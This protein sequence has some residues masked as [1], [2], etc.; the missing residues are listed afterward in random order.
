MKKYILTFCMI[1]ISVCG[2]MLSA[3]GENYNSFSLHFSSPSI[4]IEQNT[5]QDYEIV[6]ENYFKSNLDFEFS[7][8]SQIVE[9]SEPIDLGNGHYRVTILGHTPGSATLKITLL[10]GKK[11]IIIPVVVYEPISSISLKEDKDLYVLRGESLQ[12][13]S[14]MFEFYPPSTLE[15]DIRFQIGTQEIANGLIT[16][17]SETESELVVTAVSLYDENITCSFVVRVLDEIETQNITLSLDNTVIPTV[18]DEKSGYIE[19]IENDSVNYQKTLTFAYDEA[20]VYEIFTKSTKNPVDIVKNPNMENFEQIIIQATDFALREDALVIR[21][22]YADYDAYYVDLEYSVHVVSKPESILFNG[23]A[24]LGLINLFDNNNEDSA[25]QFLLSI[26]PQSADYTY[27]TLEFYTS[28]DGAIEGASYA[29]LSRYIC[30]KYGVSETYDNIQIDDLTIPIEVYGREVLP[31]DIGDEIVIRFVVQDNITS[32]IVYGNLRFTIQK[33]ATS[34]V[35]NNIYPNSTIYVKNGQTVTF[36]D[37]I[38]EETDAYVGKITAKPYDLLSSNYCTVVQTQEGLASIDITA[39]SVGEAH[40]TLVLESGLSTRITIVVKEELDVDNLWFYVSSQDDVVA[41]VEYRQFGENETLDFV[42]VR[43]LGSIRISANIPH[44]DKIDTSMYSITYE[45]NSANIVVDGNTLTFTSVDNVRNTVHIKISKLKVE[46]FALVVDEDI[47]NATT[48]DFEVICFK[49]ITSFNFDAQNVGDLEDSYSSTVNVYDLNT[50]LGYVDTSLALLQFRLLLDGVEIKANDIL[51]E[52]LGLTF[53][54]SVSSTD[55]GAGRYELTDAGSIVYGYFDKNQLTFEC[56]AV[57]SPIATFTIT[58]TIYEYGNAITSSVQV[59]IIEYVQV[60]ELWL[61]NRVDDIYLDSTDRPIV[62][63]PY[64]LP[65]NATNKNFTAWFEPD[66]GTSSTILQLQYDSNSITISYSGSGGGNGVINIVPNSLFEGADRNQYSWGLSIPISVGDGSITSPLHIGTWEQFKNIDLSK[67]YIIDGTIDANGEEISP[68]GELTGGIRGVIDSKNGTSSSITNFVVKSP[69]TILQ[70]QLAGEY[71]GLFSS[72]SSGAYV[73]NLSISGKIDVTDIQRNAYIGLIAGVNNGVIKNVSVTLN[74]ST[75]NSQSTSALY[76]GGGVGQ[77]NSVYVVDI[78]E[79]KANEQIFDKQNELSQNGLTFD[80][81]QESSTSGNI[82]T[83]YETVLPQSTMF[84]Y[85][86][87]GQTLNVSVGNGNSFIG[88]VVG[89]NT[90]L[91]KFRKQAD[92]TTFNNFGVSAQ[93]NIKVQT[94]SVNHANAGIGGFVGQNNGGNIVNILI[95][96]DVSAQ[97]S[98]NVGGLVGRMQDGKVLNNTSRVFVRGNTYVAGLIGYVLSGSIENITGNTVQAT[99]DRQRVGLFATL[100]VS[101]NESSTHQILNSA[102]IDADT[103]ITDQTNNKAL[104]YITRTKVAYT[105]QNEAEGDINTYYG[106][107]VVG[108]NIAVGNDKQFEK[109]QDVL[110]LT[111]NSIV[112]NYFGAKDTENQVYLTERNTQFLPSDIFVGNDEVS[113]TS[114]T[115]SIISIT[116]DGRIKVHGTGTAILTLTSPLNA[117]IKKQLKCV[118]TNYATTLSLYTTADYSS[119]LS[120]NSVINVSNRDSVTLYPKL[121]AYV[122]EGNM[123]IALVDNISAQLEIVSNEN[124]KAMQSANTIILQGIGTENSTTAEEISFYVYLNVDGNKRYLTEVDGEYKFVEVAGGTELNTPNAKIYTSYTQGIYNIESDKTNITLVPSDVFSIKVSY[125]TDD[126]LDEINLSVTYQQ[127]GEVFALGDDVFEKYFFVTYTQP[128]LENGRYF[129]DYTFEMNTDEVVR[130][131]DYTFTFSGANG[132]VTKNVYVTYE[133]QP[134]NNVIVKNYS[135]TD[136]ED[137]ILIDTGDGYYVYNTSYTMTETNIVTA[138]EPN[139]LKVVINPSFADYSYVEITNSTENI[140]KGNVVLFGLLQQKD[141]TIGQAVISSN[142]FFTSTGIRV[143]KQYILGG[144]LNVLYRMATNVVEGDYIT[145]NINFYNDKGEIVYTQQQKV[146]TIALNKSVSV[147]IANKDIEDH[148]Y[149]ARGYNYLLNVQTVGY[150]ITDVVIQ[151]SSPYGEIVKDN[152]AYYLRIADKVNYTRGQE[153]YDFTVTYYGTTT[154]DGVTTSGIRQSFTCTIVEY[155]LADLKNLDEVFTNSDIV[156]NRGSSVDVRDVIVD[157]IEVEYSGSAST[158]VNELKQSLRQNGVYFYKFDEQNGYIQIIPQD[159]ETLSKTQVSNQIFD[160][161]GYDLTVKYVGEDLFSL[162]VFARLQYVEGFVQVLELSDE[163]KDDISDVDIREFNVTVNQSTSLESPLP[164]YTEEDLLNMSAGNYYILM[165]NITIS[166]NYTPIDVAIAQLDGNN[167]NIIF[168]GIY[169]TYNNVENFGLFSVVDKSTV[170]RNLT[171]VVGRN[172]TFNFRNESN[173]NPFNFGLICAQNNGTITN[174]QVICQDD[175]SSLIVTNSALVA[176]TSTSNIASFVAVNNGY[177]TN[178]RVSLRIES[179]GANLSGFVAENN[180]HIASSYVKRSLIR[181]SSTNVNN[182][183]AGFVVRNSGTI[184][185]SYIEGEYTSGLSYLYASDTTFIIR[186]TSIAGAFAYINDGKISNCYANIPL[187]S[188]SVNSGFV[189]T[190][191]GEIISSYTT[192]KLGDRDTGNYPFYISSSGKIEDSYY[193]SDENF[194]VGINS[195]NSAYGEGL[196]QTLI[197]E[198]ATGYAVSLTGSTYTLQEKLF[199][200]FA[201]NSNQDITS[202][203]WFY[204]LDN[205]S[206]QNTH[207]LNT[208]ST[209]SVSDYRNYLQYSREVTTTLTNN[210]QNLKFR[211]NRPQLVSANII[212]S[213]SKYIASMQYVEET[214]ETLYTYAETA[215]SNTEGSLYNPHIIT[216]AVMFEQNFISN[217]IRYTNTQYYRLVKD[218]DYTSENLVVSSLYNYVLAGYFEGNGLTISN[219][220][221][222]TNA[223]MTSGGYFSQ[224]G[225]G[226]DYAT[227]QNVTFVPRYINLPNVISAGTVAGTVNRVYAYNITVDGYNSDSTS[228]V[229]LGKNIVG[230]VFGRTVSSFDIQNIYSSISTNAYQTNSS[231]NWSSDEVQSEILYEEGSSNYNTVSYS[232]GIIGYLGG[233]G[234]LKNAYITDGIASIGMV[235]GFMFGGVGLNAKV[236]DV[237]YQFEND[238]NNFI[239]ASAYAGVIV[240]DL[241][242]TLENVHVLAPK[243][244]DGNLLN[245]S[246]YIFV[247]T[248]KVP[249]A[250]GGICG[251]VRGSENADANLVDCSS[252]VNIEFKESIIVASVGGLVG[253][254][255]ENITIY[256]CGYYGEIVTGKN[257]VGGIIGEIKFD[258]TFG[259]VNLTNVYVGLKDGDTQNAVKTQVKA[260]KPAQDESISTYVGGLIGC[261]TSEYN[262]SNT[263]NPQPERLVVTGAKIYADITSDISIYGTS[264][265]GVDSTGEVA[266]IFNLYASK[267]IGGYNGTGTFLGSLIKVSQDTDYSGIQLNL[268]LKNLRN[269]VTGNQGVPVEYTLYISTIMK[270]VTSLVGVDSLYINNVSVQGYSDKSYLVIKYSGVT[271][272][273]DI[274]A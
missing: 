168:S 104:S 126:E 68:L 251:I 135:F 79:K 88:G 103:I 200:G 136:N 29:E 243:D 160:L 8:D 174:C 101:N 102:N 78:V 240:G 151:S 2:V 85:M 265:I 32:D 27:I 221:I 232:G 254:V 270:D 57:G 219:F 94:T 233:L 147:S 86:P 100:I 180:G 111:T 144:E 132:M 131:G 80:N 43:G 139:I 108:A 97:S 209:I 223:G 206:Y 262:F 53:S 17:D 91:L 259:I 119:L 3:C 207:D 169:S 6:V 231:G 153:G 36:N 56:D 125:L 20:Y 191:N 65:Q 228:K 66:D 241:K 64:I 261:L 120:P 167:F 87:N 213:S 205:N 109:V 154:V 203:V 122:I 229:V 227:I 269:N 199:N 176:L 166:S 236:Q 133:L 198:F 177:I 162:G 35:V 214:G 107:I 272:S 45:S 158:A 188:S 116:A 194:N 123:K 54:F 142:A 271:E 268:K 212:A 13:D 14:S 93:V 264:G 24:D 106:E 11:Q 50:P 37:F 274:I 137:V 22:K 222:N 124:V 63:Y 89:E 23:Q 156:L 163:E 69:Y 211:S 74:E 273:G 95:T 9:I 246:Y 82:N 130:V 216:S 171:I 247:L 38:V 112:L 59:S 84:V 179:Y 148:Y 44:A 121:E 48:F 55:N 12:L 46:N 152:N 182:A 92:L 18:D 114:N 42:A 49:P 60:E 195:S 33:S 115:T 267:L 58:A 175:S 249:M 255:N 256:N 28:K 70:G 71:Y 4:E 237:T 202:G 140:N 226:S 105:G 263:D 141:N 164:I 62:L 197:I 238:E 19:L 252:N 250:V 260:V 30:V 242:G 7:L 47:L 253:K 83:Y 201:I 186:A 96:G 157:N 25:K 225:N 34:F 149:V 134:I 98:R 146:L 218:I 193:L 235:S 208:G 159:T 244:E 26:A 266:S 258:K 39:H 1:L 128:Y 172:T 73:M 257:A 215:G 16:T 187:T 210:N 181:N 5:S 129:I 220:S 76:L 165:D 90:G 81:N 224:I 41:E 61:Y 183:T 145:L 10:Q 127:N 110:Q 192:S 239:R 185:T 161:S 143:M 230:G 15:R 77:N 178:S 21:V 67:Y 234:T 40:F 190:N 51:M 184:F 118:V 217:S 52:N 113:I 72:V 245:E 31:E 99:D 75:V 196:R 150:N 248:P 173:G 138:G 117:S 155:V 189:C 170:L 204:A